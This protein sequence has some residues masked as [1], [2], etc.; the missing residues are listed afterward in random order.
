MRV[1]ML[2]PPGSGKGTHAAGLARDLGVPYIR[3]SGLLARRLPQQAGQG[4][5]ARRQMAAGDLVDDDLVIE[6]V[7]ERLSKPDAQPG[8]VLDGFP[9]DLE[10]ARSLDDWLAARG[11]RLDAVILLEAADDVLVDRLVRRGAV[12][13]RVDDDPTTIVHRLHVY[14]T[15]TQPSV[16]FYASRGVLRRVDGDAPIPEVEVRVRT[17]L[18]LAS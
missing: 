13:G 4:R 3:S 2:G 15:Q 6:L 17:A 8:F 1:V 18:R 10:Q 5:D 16:D 12:E 7:Q 11:G 9:R 14:A